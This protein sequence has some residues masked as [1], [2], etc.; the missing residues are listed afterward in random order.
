MINGSIKRENCCYELALRY[1][2][3]HTGKI[4]KIIFLDSIILISLFAID[5]LTGHTF[6]FLVFYFIPVYIAAS[7]AGLVSGITFAVLSTISWF[8]VEILTG[9]SNTFNAVIIWNTFSRL[10]TFLLLALVVVYINKSNKQSRDLK[11]RTE[12]L[13]SAN[14][15]LQSFSYSISHDLRN[16]ISIIIAFS[17]IINEKKDRLDSEQTD[18]LSRIISEGHRMKEI[19][20]DLLRLSK[21]GAQEINLSMI[22]L[23]DIAKETVQHLSTTYPVSKYNI[24]IQSQMVANVD[25]GLV[26]MLYDNLIG[27]S[28]KFCGKVDSPW[29]GV[30]KERQGDD[31]VYY[32]KDNG[33]GF[34]I[35]RSEHIFEPFVRLHSSKD[36]TGTGIG[37]SIVRKIVERH[38]G[39]IWLSSQPNKGTVVFFTLPGK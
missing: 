4:K 11:R 6:S 5:Y 29:I 22:N 25:S 21:I 9:A 19:V 35:E 12:E 38:N 36:F 1:A 24:D 30:G 2:L 3:S 33:V 18:A 8:I 26:R 28:M 32:V 34:D 27:N 16:P 14:R 20:N 23:S 31:T 10:I 7:Y 17:E 15:D 39:K 37:L 13:M